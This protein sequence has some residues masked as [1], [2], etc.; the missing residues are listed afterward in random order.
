MIGEPTNSDSQ[1][2][3]RLPGFK[4][5]VVSHGPN[6]GRGIGNRGTDPPQPAS[7]P[8]DPRPATRD[9][10]P[11]TLDPRPSTLDPRPSTV[12]RSPVPFPILY[13]Q[14]LSYFCNS[15]LMRRSP[16]ACPLCARRP[17]RM[18]EP[19]DSV[20]FV[21]PSPAQASG[22]LRAWRLPRP[23]DQPADKGRPGRLAA[24]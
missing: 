6:L 1:G 3:A 21:P 13:M 4:I 2:L 11:A 18:A 24:F 8:R 7:Y 23:L 14:F 12:L 5:S 15:F 22:V 20:V 9:P 16:W 17:S 10:R 19:L